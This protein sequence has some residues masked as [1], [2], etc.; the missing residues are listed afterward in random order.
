VLWE[1]RPALRSP[2]LIAAF[3]GWNDGGSAAT[4]AASF[5]R[6]TLDATRFA[7]I[8]PDDYIDFQQT[9]PRV[10][11]NDGQ[12]REISWP[13]IE[14]FQAALPGNARDI[15][16]CI[17]TEPNL[18]WKAF[19]NEIAD[20]AAGLG[21]DLALTLGGLLADTPHT[22][23]VP[24]TGAAHDGELATRLGLRRSRYEGP[25]GIV[26]VLHD[27]LARRSVPS[28]SLWA[29]VPHYI[30]ANTNPAAALALV[31]QLEGILDVQLHPDELESAAEVFM[32]QIQQVLESDEETASYVREL[33]RRDEDDDEDDE[34]IP[35]GDELAEELQRFLR[36]RREKPDDQDVN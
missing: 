18:R 25:T 6:T 30:A 27:T 9:R 33:E 15:V 2:V 16:I 14:F 17:G 13:E 24:V 35:T 12:T 31:R 3:H 32:R 19:T 5:V 36:E 4:L 28:A 23:P 20:L 11:L 26:G 21:V 10:S 1:S 22:R 34:E 7:T 8:D 29:A